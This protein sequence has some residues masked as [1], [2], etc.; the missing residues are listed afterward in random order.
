MEI[1]SQLR[2]ATRWDLPW[3]WLAP[4]VARERLCAAA[5]GGE[6]APVQAAAASADGRWTAGSYTTVVRGNERCLV[7]YF[8][9]LQPKSDE[10]VRRKFQLNVGWF[11]FTWVENIVFCK[12]KITL[13][14]LLVWDGG[15]Y[16]LP[17]EAVAHTKV[18]TQD[19]LYKNK[20]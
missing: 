8:V 18:L 9:Q 11:L 19:F 16:V 2:V 13:F 3:L 20:K 4:F 12:L 10:I 15:K 5:A 17:F 7:V 14:N 1:L 6:V